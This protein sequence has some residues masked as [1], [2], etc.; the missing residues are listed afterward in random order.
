[1]LRP[2]EGTTPEDH[3]STKPTGFGRFC[4][5]RYDG[6]CRI[7]TPDSEYFRIF[8]FL[9]RDDKEGFAA[10][11][12][13]TFVL[14]TAVSLASLSGVPLPVI[15]VIFGKIINEFP[16]KESSLRIKL[17]QMI[18]VA[19]VNFFA[20]WGYTYC[21]G[22]V[23]T[24][25]SQS[26]RTVVLER[27]LHMDIA[28]H[29]TRKID[30]A[31]YLLVD[32]QTIQTGTGEKVGI[33]IQSISYFVTAIVV[34]LV[35]NAKFTAVLMA[36]V[37]PS[38]LL[39]T[40]IC[41]RLNR[42]YTKRLAE[43]STRAAEILGDVVR[44]ITVVQA[45][46]VGSLF[47]EKNREILAAGQYYGIR[48]SFIIAVRLGFLFF[49]A[50]GVNSLAFW[51]GIRQVSAH[52]TDAGTIY[53]IIF[54]MLDA[55]FI[56][57]QF[58][59]FLHTFSLAAASSR[60][61]GELLRDAEEHSEKP[62]IAASNDQFTWS[63]PY[64]I[65]L[66]NLRFAYPT[67]P[68]VEVLKNVNLHIPAGSF[69]AIVG[70]SGSG[71]S[72][73]T[74]LLLRFYKPTA[75]RILL[76]ETDLVTLPVKPYR[77]HVAYVEQDP[78]LFSGTIKE[79]ILHG[80]PNA[81]RLSDSQ[82][83][84]MCTVSAA[85]ANAREFIEALPAGFETLVGPDGASQLSGGQVARIALARALVSRPRVLILDEVTASLDI[86]S[87]NVVMSAIRQLHAETNMTIIMI[88]H[89]LSSVQTAD[90]IVV[91]AAGEVLEEGTHDDLILADGAYS[92][93]LATQKKSNSSSEKSSRESSAERAAVAEKADIQITTV[94]SQD[95]YIAE[96]KSICLP[97]SVECRSSSMK[98]TLEMCRPDFPIILA[99]ILSSMLTGS[100]VVAESVLFGYIISCLRGELPAQGPQ[101]PNFYCLMFFVVGIVALAAHSA[102]GFC[103]GVVSERLVS[104]LRD[105]CFHKITLQDLSFFA[106]PTHAE[107]A[108]VASIQ[109]DTAALTSLSGVMIGTIVSVTTTLIGGI[110]VAH[111]VAWRIAVVLLPALPVIVLAGYLRL[112]VLMQAQTKQETTYVKAASMATEATNAMRTVA[113]LVREDGVMREYKAELAKAE[114]G[115][116]T[117]ILQGSAIMALALSIGF[118]VYALAYWWGA[119][120]VREGR[121][122]I[123][124]FFI[125][126]PALLFSAQTAGQVFSLAPEFTKAAGAARR[127]FKLLDTRPSI[128]SQQNDGTTSSVKTSGK[129]I[130]S[131]DKV[132]RGGIEF[133]NVTFAYPT[134]P[135]TRVI[136]NLSL[137]IR[138]GEFVAIVG[139][140]G[141]GKSSLLSLIQRFYDPTRGTV[142]VDGVDISTVPV[143]QHRARIS[144]LAQDLTLFSE[145]IFFNVA[146][147]L[148]DGGSSAK[149]SQ[150]ATTRAAVEEA[151]RRVGMHEFIMSLPEGYDTRCSRATPCLSGGQIQRLALARAL[152][153]D[154]EIL[155]LDEPT[156]A[157]D[158]CSEET[159][160]R[161]VLEARGGESE[162]AKRTVVMVAHR[163]GTVVT[164]DKI[165]V[166]RK[167]KIVEM[168]T[169]E[170]LVAIGG[171]YAGMAAQQGL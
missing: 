112:R 45:F 144:I 127:I 86:H 155:V 138:P 142:L 103:F 96:K 117:F 90:K 104:R 15:G 93:L 47:R 92:E 54:L 26:I 146:V 85:L 140:S 130:A 3:G 123:V 161:A 27:V 119:R 95:S 42:R 157:L 76:N 121:Y 25:I 136:R 131:A 109:S 89:R 143:A 55:S 14:L 132:A 139:D 30:L 165:V 108:L 4:R 167:G 28:Y 118:F 48:R 169:H 35:L 66:E 153:R 36:A 116:T 8:R 122:N 1:M 37:V 59:P 51:Y 39:I 154:P 46:G 114:K 162:G 156:S 23:G 88:T 135:D 21:W 149:C 129:G 113:S 60:R 148:D 145:T 163:L 111:A 79:N 84:T 38:I 94:L 29:E 82:A 106:D 134:R 98:R 13:D 63:A 72:S 9:R 56:I 57:S 133:R 16:P 152:I 20:I 168:G 12:R 158:V 65:R 97:C 68:D 33:F 11:H 170:E 41:E 75:G 159:V 34:G 147:G 24:R 102:A 115:H 120:Q 50:Y 77:R 78:V 137:D 141:S 40:V 124:D 67:R 91:V 53:T 126:L 22:Y 70:K 71:K 19:T 61:I 87:E 5:M 31:G 74:S 62:D 58:G 44:M 150:D 64:D 32:V 49:L 10:R 83:S 73:L 171:V 160:M 128:A 18:T 6:L 166:V 52:A 125:V 105:L 107:T 69:T 164:A 100:L 81:E 151:C 2:I 80:I 17:I 43:T 7:L 110:V 99:G 101:D